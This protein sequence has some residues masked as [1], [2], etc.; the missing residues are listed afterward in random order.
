VTRH[1][2][3]QETQDQRYIMNTPETVNT[4]RAEKKDTIVE[5]STDKDVPGHGGV[6][7]HSW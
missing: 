1:H 5:L 6:L 7:P 4:Q 2:L 3:P